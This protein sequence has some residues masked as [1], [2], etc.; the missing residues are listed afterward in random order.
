MASFPVHLFDVYGYLHVQ[1]SGTM[2]DGLIQ[3]EDSAEMW[4]Q[5]CSIM[6]RS[7]VVTAD[8]RGLR[9]Y[10]QQLVLLNLN[11]S[12]HNIHGLL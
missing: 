5:Y 10:S 1:P 4:T 12:M 9:V 7:R 11:L 6:S 3:L 8:R 2:C